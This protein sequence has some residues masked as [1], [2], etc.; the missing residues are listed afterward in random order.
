[1][2]VNYGL[3]NWYVVP[4]N[5]SISFKAPLN[6]VKINETTNWR[7]KM[8]KRMKTNYSKAAYYDFI[9]PWIET[10]LLEPT[11][12]LSSQNF[13]FIE[14]VSGLLGYRGK[15]RFSSE[16]PSDKIRSE[17]VIE[18]LRWCEAKTYY[19]A[20][21][22]FDYMLEDNL[23]PVQDIKICFQDHQPTSYMQIGSKN[24]FVPYLS[25]L[26]ALMNIGPDKTK[27]IVLSGTE[28]WL[29]WD[30]MLSEVNRRGIDEKQS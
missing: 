27:E 28:K 21:G 7:I 5:K 16:L 20:K 24:E 29:F 25:V 13:S 17:R 11:P 1:M 26:D 6:Q 19:C 4:I 23:F 18:L 2:F 14:F 22:S 8:W 3:A 9:S 12:D 10:W 15:F 30:E